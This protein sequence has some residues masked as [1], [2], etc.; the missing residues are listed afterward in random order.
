MRYFIHAHVA[1]D[2]GYF[3]VPIT[4]LPEQLRMMR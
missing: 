1:V 4:L 2:H 3:S